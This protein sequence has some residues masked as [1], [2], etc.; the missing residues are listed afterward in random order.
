MSDAVD[1][2]AALGGELI[3]YRPYAGTAIQ[4]KAIIEREPSQTMNSPAGNFPI[5]EIEVLIPMDASAG[6]LRIQPR[7]DRISLVLHHGDAETT[8]C[9]VQ[10]VIQED[11][12]LLGGGGM[13]RVVVKA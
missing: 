11:T 12:G 4:F 6:M 7:K 13:F 8:E 3:T 9:M 10:K 5:N 1:M 2:V